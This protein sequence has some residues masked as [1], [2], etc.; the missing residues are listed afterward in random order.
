MKPAWRGVLTGVVAYL[1]FLVVSAPAAKVLPWLQPRMPDVQFSVVDGSLWSGRALTVQAAPVQL[2][3]VSWSLRPLA[4]LTGRL[5]FAVDAELRGREVEGRAGRALFGQPYLAAVQGRVAASD[6]LRWSGQRQQ[7][8]LAGDLA[9]DLERVVWAAQAGVPAI[10]GTLVWSPAQVLAP[11]ELSLGRAELV[12]RIEEAASRGELQASGGAL[13]VT[14][15]VVMN[16]DGKYSLDARIQ[17]QGDAPP[18]VTEFLSTFA[19]YQNGTYRLEWSDS[20]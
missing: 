3:D 1:L 14:A 4:L 19:D 6:L 18:A 15:D 10:A 13:R 20:I 2:N 12:T 9:F 8:K 17:Q 5:E 16:P 11:L 7:V